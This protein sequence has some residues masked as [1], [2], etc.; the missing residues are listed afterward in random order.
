MIK[1]GRALVFMGRENAYTNGTNRYSF[2]CSEWVFELG[3]IQ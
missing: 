3:T 1:A 2:T